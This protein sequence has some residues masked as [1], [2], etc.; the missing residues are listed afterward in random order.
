VL[1]WAREEADVGGRV[2]RIEA[3]EEDRRAQRLRVTRGVVLD[4]VPGWRLPG[5]GELERLRARDERRAPFVGAL[6]RLGG[7]ASDLDENEQRSE[8]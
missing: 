4:C 6:G 3:G 2:V 8:Q 1:E 5:A 7:G